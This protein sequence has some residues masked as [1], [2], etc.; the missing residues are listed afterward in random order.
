MADF[1]ISFENGSEIVVN[2]FFVNF[3]IIKILGRLFKIICKNHRFMC[4][5]SKQSFN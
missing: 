2:R 1:G 4:E 3:Y 5:I